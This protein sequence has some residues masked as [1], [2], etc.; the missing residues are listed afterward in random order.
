MSN[1]NIDDIL[2]CKEQYHII[3]VR[4][5]AEFAY[6]HI[7]Q[8]IN[9]PLFN[10]EERATIGTLYKKQGK[11]AAIIAGLDIVGP[12]MS[13][14]I[15]NVREKTE[16]K[17][18]VHCWRGGMRSASFSW[19]L[20][21]C[22]I[23]ATTITGGYKSYRNSI[24]EKF[25]R[26]AKIVLIGGETGSGKTEILS[27]IKKSGHQVIDLEKLANH[28]GSAFGALGENPQP[29]VEQFEN[30][31]AEEWNRLDFTKPVF[32]E[33]EAHSI[34]R[35]YIPNALWLQ[36]KT[37]PIIRIKIP[38]EKRVE[39]LVKEYGKYDIKL[40][41]EAINKI[42]KR[43]GG[44]HFKKAID[45]LHSGNLFAVAN[46]ALTYYDKAYDFNHEKR[47]YKDVYFVV[48]ETGNLS[49]IAKEIIE[50]HQNKWMHTQET[51]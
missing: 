30:N 49:D 33:D 17:I 51:P 23:K 3:D 14:L 44:Q 4:S 38:K 48:H 42:G 18:V 7:P 50:T 19:L 31:L 41:E 9:I 45:E 46:I 20:N 11:E 32:M 16:K 13:S 10:N 28:K 2:F 35:I 21:T 47:S 5:P 39:R 15:K 36:M 6:G 43:L 24:L 27:E 34:G 40:L 26:K 37:A 1:I 25:G 12:K 29:T 22:G 8:A